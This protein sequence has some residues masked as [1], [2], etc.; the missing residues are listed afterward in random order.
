MKDREA[1]CKFDAAAEQV[2]V[3]L[4]D[5]VVV[6][7]A[8][9]IAPESIDWLWKGW[10][11]H[12]KVHLL[13]GPPG[14]GKTTIAMYMASV[15]SSGG[16]WPDGTSCE[17]GNVLIWSAED[18]V[19]DTLVPR[20]IAAGDRSRCY[21]IQGTR[22]KGEV[23]SFDP[24]RDI[25]D[26]EKQIEAYG[27]FSLLILDPVVTAVS[28]D[29]NGNT[30]VRRGLQPLVDLSRKHGAAVLGITH[31]SKGTAGSD[32]VSRVIG[33]T[34]YSA[35]ARVVMVAKKTRDPDGAEKGVFAK[36]K[37]NSSTSYGG[38]SYAFE[39]VDI[40]GGIEV[41][42]IAWGQPL[43]GDAIELLA[44]QSQHTGGTDIELGKLITAMLKNGPVPATEI[45]SALES[46]GFSKG[47]INR[48]A[49]KIGVK[50]VKA[51]MSG[52]WNWHLP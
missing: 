41:S 21:F 50:K 26:V 32:P 9:D 52:G 5:G 15:V 39:Q 2:R 48:C 11:A 36:A 49:Q 14:Q 17:A 38:F 3:N 10:L 33:S 29:S 6:V 46:D 8:Q 13:A 28:G 25:S 4:S 7:S 1:L 19:S 44:E 42:R 22:N 43:T 18:D 31:F 20:L 51:G 45:Q 24:S 16:T 30:D 12:G 23:R 37:A 47:K 40:G 34:A 27:G 35:V